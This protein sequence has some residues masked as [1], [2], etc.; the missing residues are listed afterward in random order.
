MQN[1]PLKPR[2]IQLL[3]HAHNDEQELISSLSDE[4]RAA[5]GTPEHW[6]AKENIA[7]IAYWQA[8]LTER[9]AG[10]ARG[11]PAHPL[12]E[13]EIEAENAGTGDRNRNRSWS[14]VQTE[15]ETV[16]NRLLAT[17]SHFSEQQLADPTPI[18]WYGDRAL[19]AAIVGNSFRHPEEHI[20]A[21]YLQRGDRASARKI[22][23]A[24]TQ[25]LI[26]IDSSPEARATALYNLACFYARNDGPDRAIELLRQALPLRPDLV[27][28][29]KEDA[30]LAS[31][32][33]LTE[34][35]ALYAK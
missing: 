29:S 11:E 15:A 9:L 6:S 27:A 20:V 1:A 5:V 3:Q 25:A 2:L 21:F 31:L 30:D 4:E 17:V 32:R 12:E 33:G 28:W 18:G 24:A 16:F 26:D 34:Y 8:R 13:G 35:Q 10:W 22:Q 7:H 14:E 19:L 23:E